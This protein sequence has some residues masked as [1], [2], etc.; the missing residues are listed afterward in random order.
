MAI[1]KIPCGGFSY[2]DTEIA[3]EDGVIHP[4]GG[5]GIMV[6]NFVFDYDE[7]TEEG[8]ITAD[9]K[10]TEVYNAL[11]SGCVISTYRDNDHVDKIPMGSCE[12]YQFDNVQ[13]P[14]FVSHIFANEDGVDEYIT[15]MR[16]DLITDTWQILS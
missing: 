12:I 16:G 4:I 2:D 10:P 1:K 15:Y 8:T 5:G 14:T 9:K 3:F 13:Y 7:E 11:K 6:V